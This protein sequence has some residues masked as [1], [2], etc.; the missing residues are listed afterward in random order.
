MSFSVSFSVRLFLCLFGSL[1]YL[2]LIRVRFECQ[3]KT[4]TYFEC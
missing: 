1:Q 3:T 2:L 4:L